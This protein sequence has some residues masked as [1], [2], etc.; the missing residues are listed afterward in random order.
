MGDVMTATA[1]EVA[2]VSLGKIL[3]PELLSVCFG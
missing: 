2:E 1:C 3:N